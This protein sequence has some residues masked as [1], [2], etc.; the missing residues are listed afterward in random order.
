M[1]DWTVVAGIATAVG[2]LVL[3]GA[4]FIAVRS[5]HESGDAPK[6]EVDGFHRLTV[7]STSLR[8]TSASG[9]GR[10]VTRTSRASTTSAT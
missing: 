5:A 3:A 4:T 8:E 9:R 7:T 6:P 2:T 10:S 1:I